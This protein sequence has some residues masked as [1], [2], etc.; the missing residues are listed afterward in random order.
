MPQTILQL[1]DQIHDEMYQKALKFRDENIRTA[2]S[3][4]EFK[5]ILENKA[6]YIRMMWCGDEAC[7]L[8]FKEIKG[9]K[10]RC[11]LEGHK[12]IDDKCIICGKPA[13]ELVLWGIQY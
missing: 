10:S 5:D 8:K 4:D 7:E 9:I 13:K 6:G 12:H 3:Y 1:L 2:H 11:I